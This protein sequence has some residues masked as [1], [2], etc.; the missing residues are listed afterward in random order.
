MA[1]CLILDISLQNYEK[2]TLKLTFNRIPNIG[3]KIAFSNWNM[4]VKDVIHHPSRF[5]INPDE[6][7][8]VNNEYDATLYIEFINSTPTV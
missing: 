1:V 7:G 8:E 5:K 2:G 4:I 6:E 3:E